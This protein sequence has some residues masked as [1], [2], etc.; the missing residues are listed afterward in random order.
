MKHPD[1]PHLLAECIACERGQ[2]SLHMED[3]RNS[4][5][6]SRKKYDLITIE[7]SSV[8]FAGATNLYSREFYET[9]HD[10]LAPEGVLQQW[11]QFHHNGVTEVLATLLTLRDVF[12]HVEL[13]LVGGQGIL[14]ASAQPLVLRD[15]AIQ[16]LSCRPW[17]PIEPCSSDITSAPSGPGR[18]RENVAELLDLLPPPAA[19]APCSPIG[20]TPV[21]RASAPAWRGSHPFGSAKAQ[22]AERRQSRCL[23][24]G[25][26]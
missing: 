20:G 6:R 18:G 8:W 1:A 16:R 24:H 5:L 9:A 15:P 4:L 26:A 21:I 10:R 25:A 14:L 17:L 2:L 22:P 19:A 23:P 13:Y 3:G 12:D 11:V 7:I